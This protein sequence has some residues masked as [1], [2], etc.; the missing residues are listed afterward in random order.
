MKSILILAKITFQEMIR[1]KFF[2]VVVFVSFLLMGISL[3]LGSLSFAEQKRI[4]VDLG[5]SAIEVCTLGIALFSGSFMI[6]REIEKQTC[7]LLL[8]KP[9]SRGQFLI[10]KWLGMVFLITMTNAILSVFLFLLMQQQEFF[11]TFVM[12]SIS[13]WMKIIVLLSLV[14]LFSSVVRPVFCLLFGLTVYLLGHWLSDLEF[15]AKK[16]NDEGVMA[17]FRLVHELTP[18]FYRFNWK[19]Y[20]FLEVGIASKDWFSMLFYLVVWSALLLTFAVSIFRRRDIV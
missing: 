7:L 2:V 6:S 15:F 19:S 5:F 1:E 4:L 10:G 8:S 20:H 11:L 9:L 13:I 18:Q 12:S 14:F 3:I 16:A 17:L